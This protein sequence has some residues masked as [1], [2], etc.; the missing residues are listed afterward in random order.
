MTPLVI[1]L[2]V[3]KVE[4]TKILPTNRDLDANIS[5]NTTLQAK[6]LKTKKMSP[7]NSK[8]VSRRLSKGCELQLRVLFVS[9]PWN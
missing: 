6:M 2:M 4:A 1:E 8:P 9:E 3:S 7:I 5:H